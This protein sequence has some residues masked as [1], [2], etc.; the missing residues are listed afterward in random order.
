MSQLTNQQINNTYQGLIKLAD[1]TTG[2][3]SSLQSIQDGLG[4]DLP[5]K[6]SN[7][8]FISNTGFGIPLYGIG[9]YYGQGFLSSAGSPLA[10]VQN[11]LVAQAFYDRGDLSYS[12]ISYNLITATTTT[13]IVNISFYNSQWIDGVGLAPYQVVASGYTWS[14]TTTGIKTDTFGTDLSFSAYG[15]GVYFMVYSIDNANVT[16][17]VRYGTATAN[18]SLTSNLQ[19]SLGFTLAA[20]ANGYVSPLRNPTSTAAA[21]TIAYNLTSYPNPFTS[22]DAANTATTNVASFGFVL[23]T[24][25]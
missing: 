17:S 24:R 18:L 3:T 25:K 16:P 7:N 22:A 4:N 2:V 20:P 9:D 19:F 11:L 13:D 1:S 12:A 6:V 21:S 10:G 15:P 8:T 5:M 14:T 23:H